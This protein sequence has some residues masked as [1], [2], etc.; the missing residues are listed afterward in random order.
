MASKFHKQIFTAL[1]P[2]YSVKME[3]KKFA[4]FRSVGKLIFISM[5]I[6]KQLK[7]RFHFT[8]L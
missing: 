6:S 4:Y 1:K 3:Q 7:S 8:H 5:Q 2:Y